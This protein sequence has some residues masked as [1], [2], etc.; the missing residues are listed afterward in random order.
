MDRFVEHVCVCLLQEEEVLSGSIAPALLPPGMAVERAISDFLAKLAQLAVSHVQSKYGA[1]M[2]MSDVQWCLTVP[3]IWDDSAKQQMIRCAQ[4][5]GMVTGAHCPADMVNSASPHPLRIVLESEAAALFC[6]KKAAEAL[7]L[8]KGHQ[9]V[10]ADVGGGTVDIVV[11]SLADDEGR[12]LREVAMSS[13]GLCGGTYVDS[14]FL[15]Y[16]THRIPCFRQYVEQNPSGIRVIMRRW[17]EI[18]CSF[19]GSPGW[20][21]Q[22]FEIPTRLAA[23]WRSFD[24]QL[25]Y[26]DTT[27]TIGKLSKVEYD[28]IEM[29]SRDMEA[30]F[31][32]VVNKVVESIRAQLQP[33]VRALMVV[34][35][36][37]ASAYLMKRIHEKLGKQVPNIINPPNPGSAICQGAVI[38]GLQP[39]ILLCR[40][41]RRTYGIKV[42]RPFRLASDPIKTLVMYDGRAYR[43]HIFC[44]YVRRGDVVGVDDVVANEHTPTTKS[45]ESLSIPIYS[46]DSRDP[47][48]TDEPGVRREGKFVLD[49]SDDPHNLGLERRVLVSMHFGRTSIQVHA[50]RVNFGDTSEVVKLEHTVPFRQS[51]PGEGRT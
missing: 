28:E 4:M 9:F 43:S 51:V 29:T 47:R 27:T 42:V 6:Y 15:A 16:L 3:A 39:D 22:M 13:G 20:G 14:N 37:S 18:K 50:Q 11:H 31:D 26:C 23:A 35:G 49:I 25:Q 46:S 24:Q 48:F 41:S 19:D 33:E 8:R 32:P 10:V 40:V 21:S 7:G 38:F 17:E 36:F 2:A 34:G 5:A 12:N 1:H 45:Q 30:I 44:V